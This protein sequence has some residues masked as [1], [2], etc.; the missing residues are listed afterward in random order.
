MRAN[1]MTLVEHW[2]NGRYGGAGR[3]L[4]LWRRDADGLLFLEWRRGEV[5]E[6]AAEPYESDE[7]AQRH[8]ALL[9]SE[10]GPWKRMQ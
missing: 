7:A 4:W 10:Y 9:R 1:G 2:W 6:R 8:L 3:H 5:G